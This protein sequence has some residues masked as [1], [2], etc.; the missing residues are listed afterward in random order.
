MFNTALQSRCKYPNVVFKAWIGM[1]VPQ[2]SQWP[3]PQYAVRR[4]KI[5]VLTRL[6]YR[7]G[8]GVSQSR[9]TPERCRRRPGQQAC[10]T[11][12]R[13]IDGSPPGKCWNSIHPW[14][15]M[16]WLIFIYMI[17]KG[18]RRRELMCHFFKVQR[19]SGRCATCLVRSRVLTHGGRAVPIERW[20][21]VLSW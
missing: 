15:C 5:M 19:T 4:C 20:G 2:G 16:G 8:S 1:L 6:E 13:K 12:T 10:G 9:C 18:S 17:Q 3:R 11:E 7:W 21:I 14:C